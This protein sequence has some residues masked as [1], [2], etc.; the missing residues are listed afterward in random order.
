MVRRAVA[1]IDSGEPRGPRPDFRFDWKWLWKAHEEYWSPE[2]IECRER[3]AKLASSRAAKAD[4]IIT[5]ERAFHIAD[6]FRIVCDGQ[7]DGKDCGNVIGYPP[8][9]E[10]HDGLCERCRRTKVIFPPRIAMTPDG[11]YAM[12]D[13]GPKIVSGEPR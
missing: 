1:E 3:F 10:T 11:I 12:T 5:I 4:G 7:I 9:P 8:L 13:D 6:S 2:A